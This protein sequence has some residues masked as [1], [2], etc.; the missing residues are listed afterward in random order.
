MLQSDILSNRQM[1]PHFR[2]FTQ[3]LQ[4]G[5]GAWL[6]MSSQLHKSHEHQQV[7]NG[8]WR[9]ESISSNY[10]IAVQKGMG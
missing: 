4:A 3:Q 6:T 2:G 8:L 10:E 1:Q 7:M 5:G 9:H